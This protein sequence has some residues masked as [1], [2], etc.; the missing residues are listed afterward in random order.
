VTC[1]YNGFKKNKTK[2]GDNVFVGSGTMIVP[3]VS[4]EDGSMIGA[5]STIT[6]DVPKDALAIERAEQVNITDGAED[7]EKK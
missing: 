6:K 7:L 3:P 4:I 1:N 2:I 5:N